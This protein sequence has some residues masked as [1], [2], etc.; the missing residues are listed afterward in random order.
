MCKGL[1]FINVSIGF[2]LFNMLKIKKE[3]KIQITFK[4]LLLYQL[5]FEH[6]F[7]QIS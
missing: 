5:T 6:L 3:F 4:R 1:K 7:L 2:Y